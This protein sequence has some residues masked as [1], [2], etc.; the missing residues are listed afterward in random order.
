MRHP[1]ALCE[2]DTVGE[3]TRLWAHVH[4]MA[5]AR[6]GCDCSLGDGVFVESGARIGHRVTIKNGALIW[7][8]VVIEDDV[9]IGP[10]VIFTNDAAPRSPRMEEV[11]AR[12]QH[13]ELW[14]LQTVVRQGASIAAGAIILP[15]LEIGRYALVGAGAV[16][17]RDV[18][19]HQVVVGNPARPIGWVCTCGLRLDDRQYCSACDLDYDFPDVESFE[20]VA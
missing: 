19:P 8:G 2:S 4:V 14:R 20:R 17:T 5:G 6:V 11:R 15:G 9:F 3:G 1:L 16:V 18:P 13:P 12:Y 10:R 7:D